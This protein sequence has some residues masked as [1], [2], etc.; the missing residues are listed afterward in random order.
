MQDAERYEKLATFVSDHKRA[1]FDRLASERTAHLT[2]VLEDAYQAQNASAVI[3]TCDLLGIRDVHAIERRN[4]FHMN[5]EV[6]LGSEKWMNLVRHH[7]GE[8]PTRDCIE[9]LRAN[10]YRIIGTSPH[11]E[12]H[13]PESLPI[14]APLA[15]CFGTELEGLSDELLSMCDGTL[16]IPMHG[17]TESFN[18]SVSVGITMYTLMRRLRDSNIQW[19]LDDNA[20]MAL[21][22][23]WVR[24]ALQDADA[25]E[26]RLMGDGNPSH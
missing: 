5:P 8:R 6:A 4:R 11:G 16:R 3:R 15:C 18:L 9:T 12:S 19:R 2:V 26:R 10:G 25:I 14:D 23:Q 7:K 21:K 13:T 24:A 1:L 22:L 20:V 17:F